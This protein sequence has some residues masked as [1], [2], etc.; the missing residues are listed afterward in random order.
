MSV[1]AGIL[2]L[3]AQPLA[4]ERLEE[5][6]E[7]AA[8]CGPDGKSL[9]LDGPLGMVYCPF[10]TTAES[11]RERQPEMCSCGFVLTWDGRLDN[12]DEL[13][14]ALHDQL[15]IDATDV[16]LIKAAFDR[17]GLECLQK[18][19]G[20]WALVIWNPQERELILA[21][22]Y[23]GIRTLYYHL[24]ANQVVWCTN[25]A[26]LAERGGPLTLSEEYVAGYL[27]SWP[28]AHLTPYREIHAVPPG[29]FVRIRNG[30]E[31]LTQY[32]AF[33]P[34]ATTHHRTDIQYEE[35]FRQLFRQAVRRRLRCDSPILSELSGGLDSS[36][37]VCMA[38]DIITNE[39]AQTPSIDTFS[40]WDRNEPN[41]DDYSYFTKVEEQRGRIGH[42]SEISGTGDTFSFGYEDVSW[43]PGF[44]V[45]R[46]L[47]AA[48]QKIVHNGAY[49]VVLSGVGGDEFL[50]G[51]LDP[52]VQLAD[53]LANWKLRELS[54]QLVAWSRSK[55]YPL[56]HL[57]AETV[58]FLLPTALRERMSTKAKLESWINRAFAKKYKL[59]RRM[60][61]AAEGP[62]HW[63]PSDRDWAQTISSLGRQMTYFG[64]SCE[65]TRYPYLDRD[66][67]E[68]LVSIPTEQILRPGQRRS[69]MRRALAELLPREI[70]SRT[71][72]ASTGRC[73]TQTVEKHW[74]RLEA[75]VNQP[76]IAKLGY[77]D[78]AEFQA[79]LLAIKNGHLSPF[80][81]SF[82]RAL[83]LE[84][85]LNEML[86]R[87]LSLTGE[88]TAVRPAEPLR[89]E[90]PA[91]V[92]LQRGCNAIPTKV[93]VPPV[94][95]PP[96]FQSSASSVT[97][98]H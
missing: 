45:R 19:V 41:D 32:W 51:A 72:K 36:S 93:L 5:L 4:R 18:F 7:L 28:D 40:F 71:T 98:P 26:C 95:N 2:N 34:S 31:S 60:L 33:A 87:G 12:R 29:S 27:A 89:S 56:A 81:L 94:H 39:G 3:D 91:S 53:L 8:R 6:S 61:A 11:R 82:L 66:L 96:A 59:G 64:P 86:L 83:S 84:I 49:R 17:W 46:E 97:H 62:L 80:A 67:V 73:V 15:G 77:V 43:T 47:A 1:Q 55:R 74:R 48:K 90:A 88:Q 50:G 65:E 16:A 44:G 35:H 23:I 68:F 24:T 75:I 37:I 85:W 42:H 13:R 22:D 54:R 69:L 10:C 78:L 25:L 21:R 38:D 14:N 76:I 9:H 58:T 52:R 57:L 30:I 70:L 92:Q 79:A 63:L 20:D